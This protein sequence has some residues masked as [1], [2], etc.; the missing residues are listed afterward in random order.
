MAK[1]LTVSSKWLH[2]AATKLEMDAQESLPAWILLGQARRYCENMGKAA[3]L[4]RAAEMKNIG[5][6]REF[7][8]NNGVQA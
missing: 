6:R 5:Q 3:V 1:H 8:R 2:M 4:R 7:L